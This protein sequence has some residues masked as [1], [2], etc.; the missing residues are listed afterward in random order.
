MFNTVVLYCICDF[1][2]S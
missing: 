1:V 2:N